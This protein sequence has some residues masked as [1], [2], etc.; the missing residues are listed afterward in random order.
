M[1]ER[2]NKFK[3][4]NTSIRQLKYLNLF[5]LCAVADVCRRI[6]RTAQVCFSCSMKKDLV[7][8]DDIRR[9]FGHFESDIIENFKSVS[10]CQF[11]VT[12][13]SDRLWGSNGLRQ[14]FWRKIIEL[15]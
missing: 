3:Y 12:F 15:L 14:I 4:S 5:D 2:S 8:D 13:M 10:I 7:L 1:S 11:I 9:D 6:K